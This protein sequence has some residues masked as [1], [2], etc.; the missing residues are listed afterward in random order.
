M[1]ANGIFKKR[2]LGRDYRSLL[3]PLQR[4]FQLHERG[5]V[6]DGNP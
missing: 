3:I 2:S 6:V 1:E 5:I 4:E